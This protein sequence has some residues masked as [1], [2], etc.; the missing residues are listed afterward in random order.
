MCME[1]QLDNDFNQLYELFNQDHDSL[2]ETLKVSLLDRFG[3]Y[4]QPEHILVLEEGDM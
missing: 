1:T 2:F 3:Q 4:E